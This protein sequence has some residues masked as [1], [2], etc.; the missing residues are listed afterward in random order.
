MADPVVS[1]TGPWSTRCIRTPLSCRPTP[2]CWP[3]ATAIPT[4]S[5]WGRDWR[6]SSIPT[7]IATWLWRGARK[8]GRLLAGAGIDF[9]EYA[10]GLI[11]ADAV[12]DRTS[13]AIFDAWLQT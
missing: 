6:S 11:A 10:Q 9:D 3:I 4:P 2:S 12:L 13:R 5:E 8:T 7:P 1:K